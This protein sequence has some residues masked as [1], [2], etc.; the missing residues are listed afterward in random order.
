MKACGAK[1]R[2]FA[3]W[4]KMPV[5]IT[6]PCVRAM[7]AETRFPMREVRNSLVVM[8]VVLFM[9]LVLR[10]LAA[11]PVP[12]GDRR[13]EGQGVIQMQVSPIEVTCLRVKHA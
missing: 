8:V 5:S 10:L 11:Q 9:V 12:S 4:A 7:N 6:F 1:V 2:A 13:S 3:V